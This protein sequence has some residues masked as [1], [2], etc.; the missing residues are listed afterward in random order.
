MGQLTFQATLGGAINLAGPNIATTT[1][2]TLPSADGTNGQA[3]TTNGS[4]TLA[5]ATV[6][7]SAATPTALGT[8]YGKQTTSGGTPYLTAIG[9]AAGNSVTGV[10][11]SAFGVSALYTNTT[12][13]RN[14]AMGYQAGYTNNGDRNLFVG[15]Q[16]GYSNTTGTGNSFVGG[17]DSSNWPAGYSNTEGSDNSAFGGGALRSNTTG[18]SN[19]AIGTDALQLN[20]TGG[21]N[22]AVGRNALFSNTTASLNCAVGYQ[23]LVYN[24]TGSANTAVGYGVMEANTTAN[25]CTAVGYQTLYS[26]TTGVNNSAYGRQALYSNTTGTNN[27]AVGFQALYTHT[28]NYNTALGYQ[29]L[30]SNTSNNNNTGI[31]NESLSTATGSSNTGCGDRSGYQLTSGNY[32]CFFGHYAYG[33]AATNS[34][35]IVIGYNTVGKGGSTGFINPGS[36]GVYQGNNSTLW[37]VTSDQRLKKNIVDNNTGLEKLTQI[38]VRNFEYRVE[39]EITELPTHAAIKKSGVQLGVIAQE[40]QAVL[41]ECVKTES[42]GVMS[43]DADNLTWYMI[44]AIKELKA[45]LDAYKAS[46]P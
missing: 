9:Y 29:A 31:G 11:V 18:S 20:T 39:D 46:H 12:G 19:T 30:Y 7:A 35:E 6:G 32:N 28:G 38:R 40:L 45:E 22:T 15:Y 41:P 5:F 34:Y 8:V 25:S 1:T 3:L 2:F 13:A 37:S 16:V 36:G 14:T 21:T 33:S 24:T 44:N 27:T 43:V 10:G 17:S 23:A 4:G 42:T 26:N